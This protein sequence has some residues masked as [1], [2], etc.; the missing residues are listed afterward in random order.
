MNTESQVFLISSPK[1]LIL[2]RVPKCDVTNTS[3]CEI[4]G[5]DEMF[6]KN[7][8]NACLPKINI[9]LQFFFFFGGGGV[10]GMLSLS[11]SDD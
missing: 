10:G 11:C 8:K 2:N 9:L 4:M 6:R 7:M 1:M 5:F 3:I